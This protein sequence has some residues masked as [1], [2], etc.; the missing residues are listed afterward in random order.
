MFTVTI[1]SEDRKSS[2]EQFESDFFKICD[3][4]RKNNRALVFAFILY[5]FENEHIA[6]ILEDPHYWLSLHSISGNYLTVFSLHYKAEDMKLKLMEMTK[7]RMNHGTQKEFNM[8]LTDQNPSQETN[9]FIHK[10][11]GKDFKIKYPSVLFF[12][13]KDDAVSDSRLIQLDQEEI[14]ASF[15]ELKQYVKIAAEALY[16]VNRENKYNVDELF[17]LVDQ[18]VSGQRQKIQIK[19]GIKIVTSIADL[20]TTITGLNPS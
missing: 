15:L 20:A 11:F 7:Q 1:N 16:E 3:E 19:K 4:H 8:I 18:S 2:Y 9:Q 17:S 10:Y 12:Q 13:V 6:K 5:D 14:E